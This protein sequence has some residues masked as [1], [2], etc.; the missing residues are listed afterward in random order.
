MHVKELS[1][2]PVGPCE[3]ICRTETC[4]YIWSVVVDEDCMLDSHGLQLGVRHLRPMDAC[5]DHHG[6]GYGGDCSDGS[7]SW[8]VVM[9][10]RCCKGLDLLELS[11]MVGKV[12]RGES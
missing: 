10:T 9:G 8:V 7:L 3:D 5:M 12:S 4:G 6:S 11:Q 1:L 2:F